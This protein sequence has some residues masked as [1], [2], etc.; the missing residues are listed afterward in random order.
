VR[1][2]LLNGEREDHGKRHEDGDADENDIDFLIRRCR[3]DHIAQA[4][5]RSEELTDH[6]SKYR[7]ADR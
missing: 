4:L 7:S 3:R 2:Q 1:F 5:A 6:H